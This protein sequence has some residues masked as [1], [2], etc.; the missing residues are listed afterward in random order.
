M[1]PAPFR[2]TPADWLR[3]IL[4]P[5]RL[6]SVKTSILTL[7]LVVAGVLVC[8]PAAS[9]DPDPVLYR[10]A[11]IIPWAKQTEEH[12]FRSPRNYD[13]TVEYYQD[14]FR[15]NPRIKRKKIINIGTVR[16]VHFQNTRQG[17]RWEGL[18]VYEH[19]GAAWIFVVF[20]DE[21]LQK[22]EQEKKS[23]KTRS[24]KKRRRRSDKKKSG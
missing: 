20:S 6:G 10:T 23:G 16:A 5:M 22:I 11:P 14:I 4:G 9:R 12:R 21:E 15:G 1:N 13:G 24:R 19:K 18:N 8:R 2:L 7:A 17:A 3:S